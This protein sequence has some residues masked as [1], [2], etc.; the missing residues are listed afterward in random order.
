MPALFL[1][2]FANSQYSSSKF[3]RAIRPPN[4]SHCLAFAGVVA[5]ITKIHRKIGKEK[6][7][8]PH[9]SQLGMIWHKCRQ[10]YIQIVCFRNEHADFFH[11]RFEVFLSPLLTVK[12]NAI[13]NGNFAFPALHCEHVVL[14]CFLDP[15]SC[16]FFHRGPFHVSRSKS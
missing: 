15:F 12:T 14:F 5:G 4:G 2:T 6:Q 7:P 3:A 8:S 16:R 9:G 10:Q 1:G 13:M 11:Q